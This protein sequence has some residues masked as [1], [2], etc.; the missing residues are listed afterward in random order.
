M[1]F[2]KLGK[3]KLYPYPE[4]EYYASQV[5]AFERPMKNSILSPTLIEYPGLP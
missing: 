1:F 4:K 5:P 3:C 2:L